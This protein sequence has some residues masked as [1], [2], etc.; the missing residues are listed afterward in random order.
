M[1]NG[2][3]AIGVVLGTKNLFAIDYNFT[4]QDF[5]DDDLPLLREAMGYARRLTN[6]GIIQNFVELNEGNYSFYDG[7]AYEKSNNANN[8]NPRWR[9]RS[10]LLEYQVLHLAETDWDVPI[11][12]YGIHARNESWWG[13]ANLNTISV[14]SNGEG[15]FTTEG[16]F[17]FQLNTWLFN[18]PYQRNGQ[19][20]E[21]WG[22]VIAHEM[23]HNLGHYHSPGKYGNEFQINLFENCVG[24]GGRYKRHLPRHFAIV[25]GG[26]MP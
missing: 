24:Y 9:Q 20:P 23:L 8:P 7:K 25:C 21:T 14:I 22:A 2:L 4:P 1:L 12:I 11:D 13:R 3:T 26:R 16:K 6:K 17:E 18:S 10:N 5:I 19:N 15:Q